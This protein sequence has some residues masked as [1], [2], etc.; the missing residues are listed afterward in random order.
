M[1]QQNFKLSDLPTPCLVEEIYIKKLT[2]SQNND[3]DKR[4]FLGI[5]KTLQRIQR[6]TIN[7]GLKF[8]KD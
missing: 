3:L 7:N 8:Y 2:D 4:E 1:P 6:K 5:N